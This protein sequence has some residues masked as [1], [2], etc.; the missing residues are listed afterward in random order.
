MPMARRGADGL[1]HVAAVAGRRQHEQR[2]AGLAPRLHAAREDAVEALVVGRAGEVRHVADG[3]S[4][5]RPALAA[6]VTGQLLREMHRVAHRPAVAA[7][8]DATAALQALR[9]PV[10][11]GSDDALAG[12]ELLQPASSAARRSELFVRA[13]S[14]CLVKSFDGIQSRSEELH[15]HERPGFDDFVS[16]SISM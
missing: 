3:L 8:Q 2:V 13:L 10:P 15:V 14:P 6:E 11:G 16:E 12:F 4:G 7:R 9:Q 1:D 5:E